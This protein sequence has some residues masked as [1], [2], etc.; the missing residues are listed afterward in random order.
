MV[1]VAEIP[2]VPTN[3]PGGSNE[4]GANMICV[5][6]AAIVA[7]IAAFGAVIAA[8]LAPPANADDMYAAIAYSPSTGS[9]SLAYNQ[10]L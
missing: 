10:G 2:P 3:T 5:E 7:G 8:T 4:V 9:S 1:V 6:G